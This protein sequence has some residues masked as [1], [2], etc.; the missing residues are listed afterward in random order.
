[1]HKLTIHSTINMCLSMPTPHCQHFIL[2]SIYHTW[3]FTH[4]FSGW[5]THVNIIHQSMRMRNHFNVQIHR[6]LGNIFDSIFLKCSQ[7]TIRYFTENFIIHMLMFWWTVNMRTKIQLTM[8]TSLFQIKMLYDA[9]KI[10]S[11][12]SNIQ[13][14]MKAISKKNVI[15]ECFKTMADFHALQN[16]DP[17]K[18]AINIPSVWLS[19]EIKNAVTVLTNFQ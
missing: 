4:C 3:R 13:M 6:I 15:F 10:F 1:M 14:E 2:I 18:N 17:I 19:S 12:N 5:S 9:K 8:S 16:N 7:N 11:H